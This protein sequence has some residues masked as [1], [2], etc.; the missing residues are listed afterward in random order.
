MNLVDREG[1]RPLAFAPSMFRGWP[2]GSPIETLERL[3]FAGLRV[4]F[5][6]AN[7]IPH[8]CAAFLGA[9]YFRA[10]GKGQLYG[11]SARCLAVDAATDRLEEFPAFREFWPVRPDAE[12]EE[13]TLL[14]YRR[15]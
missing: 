12:A 2:S 3:G 13:M 1:V 8:E 4:R 15:P 11:V 5:P 10:V 14:A 9:S 7:R 6:L